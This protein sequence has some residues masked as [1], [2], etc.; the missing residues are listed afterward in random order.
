MLWL[1]LLHLGH[2]EYIAGLVP[3]GTTNGATFMGRPDSAAWGFLLLFL[4]RNGVFGSGLELAGWES[5]R[6]FAQTTFVLFSL[7]P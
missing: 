6:G 5:Q 1:H 7:L 3:P 4:P 2:L